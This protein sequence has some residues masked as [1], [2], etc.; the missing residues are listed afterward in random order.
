MCCCA[1]APLQ[2]Y[3][4]L[5]CWCRQVAVHQL[6]ACAGQQPRPEPTVFGECCTAG[7]VCK[8]PPAGAA[9]QSSTRAAAGAAEAVAAQ[10]HVHMT[11]TAA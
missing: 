7:A 6:G 2:V 10:R 5:L 1:D 4:L 3:M 11:A 8:C 9:V